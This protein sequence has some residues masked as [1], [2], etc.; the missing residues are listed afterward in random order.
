M[1]ILLVLRERAS[2][3]RF[4]CFCFALEF[5]LRLAFS[6]FVFY[7]CHIAF[8]GVTSFLCFLWGLFVLFR[9]RLCLFPLQCANVYPLGVFFVWDWHRS[10]IAFL[11]RHIISLGGRVAEINQSTINLTCFVLFPNLAPLLEGGLQGR[12]VKGKQKNTSKK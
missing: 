11:G 5:I 2:S 8:S 7:R 4:L 6:L 12:K 1:Y 10:H 9:F 3:V